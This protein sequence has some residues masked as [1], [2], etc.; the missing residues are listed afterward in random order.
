M[1]AHHAEPDEADHATSIVRGEELYGTHCAV[2]HGTDRAGGNAGPSLL[3]VGAQIDRTQVARTI[4]YGNGRM[5]PLPHVTDEQIDDVFNFLAGQAQSKAVPVNR[6]SEGILPD[7]PVVASGGA[8]RPAEDSKPDPRGNNDYPP[9]IKVP[10]TRYYTDYGLGYSYIMTPPWSQ[11]IAYDLNEGAIKWRRPLGQDRDATA[12]G[13]TGSGM[14]HGAGR[15]GM[16]VTANGLVFSTARDGHVYAFNA[17]NG[18]L[19]WSGKLPSGAQGL[20]AMFEHNGREYL[21]ICATTPLTWG[22]DSDSNGLGSE[23]P[24]GSGGY[25]AFALPEDD[26]R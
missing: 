25:V 13:F 22:L 6:G 24:P 17:E 16:I 10:P 14:P 26:Q 12:A 19:L 2:C 23:E 8:P 11:I 15:M 4:I 21:V 9:G 3:A 20:P 1:R 5:P 7:G 18:D